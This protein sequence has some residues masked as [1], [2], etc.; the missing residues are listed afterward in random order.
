MD[1]S[2]ESEANI[3]KNDF[4]VTINC[5]GIGNDVDRAE[6]NGIA[7]EPDG[8]EKHVYFLEEHSLPDLTAIVTNTTAG[9]NP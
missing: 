2:P 6:L 3:L 9:K 5:I 1:G 4:E 7:S 8:N